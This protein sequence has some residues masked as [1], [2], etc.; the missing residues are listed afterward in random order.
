MVLQTVF[1]WV[2]ALCNRDQTRRPI[3]EVTLGNY[4]VSGEDSNLIQTLLTSRIL[5]K[6]KNVLDL[7][8]TRV[9]QTVKHDTHLTSFDADYLQ[10][11]SQT[12]TQT[13]IKMTRRFGLPDVRRQPA[14]SGRNNIS[15]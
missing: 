10:H 2:E 15:S 11:S 14:Q 4:S 3:L 7:L 5:G 8:G 13:L 1:C 12:L 6:S 9:E